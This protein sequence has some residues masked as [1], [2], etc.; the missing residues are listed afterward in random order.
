MQKQTEHN[1]RHNQPVNEKNLLMATGLNLLITVAEMV[2]G[3]LSNSLALLSD[4][5]HN[6]SDTA[7][8][9]IAWIAT[10]ISKK[11]GS[12]KKTFGY[13]RIEILSAMLNAT[14]LVILCFYLFRE[15]W[16][17]WKNPEEIDTGIMLAVAMLGL[18]ANIYA[19]ILL[20]KDSTKN[21]NVR[22]AY[23]HLIGDSLSSVAVIIGGV[24]IQLYKIYWIDPLITIII[25]LFILWQAFGILKQT[26]NIL[27][28]ATPDSLNLTKI[29]KKIEAFEEVANMHHVHAWNLTDNDIHFEAHIEL[30]K[31]LRVSEL[32]PLRN[33]IESLLKE[34]YNICHFTLQFEFGS[35][36]ENT[37]ISHRE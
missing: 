2:G 20:H 16:F 32:Q 3:L 12:E 33:N 13:K 17:R 25:G 29:K 5:L 27:M 21:I 6:L 30:K 36:H 31:D 26:V 37:L 14:V 28:Q 23:L 18:L 19:A 9:F 1:H 11:D 4:S 8:T 24:L 7:A 22:A 34:Q 35:D 10:R 15:A